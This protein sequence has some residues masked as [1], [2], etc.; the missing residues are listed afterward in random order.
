[1]RRD[2]AEE[3]CDDPP[4][5]LAGFGARGGSLRSPGACAWRVKAGIGKDAVMT[6]ILG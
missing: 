3:A 4:P 1:M 5:P 6:A 2:D